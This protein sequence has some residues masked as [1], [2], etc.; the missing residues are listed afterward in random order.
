M[1]SKVPLKNLLKI[2]DPRHAW[3]WRCD[4]P[5]SDEI[6]RLLRIAQE[7]AEPVAADATAQQ[8]IGRVRYLAKHGWSDSI[9]I[10][11]GVPCAGY[12]GPKWPVID[13]N[14]RLWAA[15][16]RGCS[17]IDVA[18]TG[19]INHAARLLGVSQREIMCA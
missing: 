9:E 11:V 1:S 8:H 14:H 10:D 2:C 5:S 3:P 12:P 7:I 16:I 18:V 19:Q 4:P 15:T 6:S 13:G 17:L